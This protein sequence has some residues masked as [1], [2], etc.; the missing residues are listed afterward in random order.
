MENKHMNTLKTSSSRFV[1]QSVAFTAATTLTLLMTG[2]RPA[3]AQAFLGQAFILDGKIGSLI[4]VGAELNKV[5]LPFPNGGAGN[6][7][8]SNSLGITLGVQPL[9]Q[10][11]VVNSTTAESGAT[12]N[13]TATIN[14]LNLLPTF[15][16]FAA[17]NLSLGAFGALNVVSVTAININANPLVTATVIAS[18]ATDTPLSSA[19]GSSTITNL[20][21]LGSGVTVT[22]SPNQVVPINV[23]LELSA[24]GGLVTTTTTAQI[25]EMILNEQISPV[26][27]FP[28]S[29]Q[30]NAL[31]VRLFPTAN[32]NTSLSGIPI[33]VNANLTGTLADTDLVFSSSSAGVNA[34]AVAPEPSALA[35]LLFV[36]PFAA[37]RRYR[38]TKTA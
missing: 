6:S 13:S 12:V 29:I 11:G 35:L 36:A 33:N 2:A 38:R 20:Q 19:S 30:V 31:R 17:T 18:Q 9:V 25:G 24:L 23:G 32:V 21:L 14:N 5:E 10:T 27:G 34:S 22:G 3:T 28:D 16:T 26:A 7:A 37:R 4:T 1:L 8:N 15:N